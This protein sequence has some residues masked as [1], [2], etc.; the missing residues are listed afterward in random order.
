MAY[1]IAYNWFLKTPPVMTYIGN[2]KFKPAKLE[3]L[4]IDFVEYMVQH[5]NLT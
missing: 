3:G 1:S 2:P 4:A 5:L